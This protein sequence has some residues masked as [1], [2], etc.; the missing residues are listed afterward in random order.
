MSEYVECK[1]KMKDR[2]ALVDALKMLGFSENEIEVHDDPQHLYGYHGDKRPEKAH[3]IIRRSNVGGSS[4]DIGFV[5][6]EDGTFEAI[7]SEFDRNSPGKHAKKY[8]GYNEAFRKDLACNYT[9][10]LYTRVAREKGY[11]VKKA[12]KGKRVVLTL[13][14]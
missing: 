9:E 3:V 13:T 14:K 7:I 4:N 6:K 12:M 8:G 1:T 11:Q 5:R 2:R 10:A